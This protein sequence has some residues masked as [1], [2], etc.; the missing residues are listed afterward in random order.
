MKKM[1][2]T[3]LFTL[4]I[5][6]MAI[7]GYAQVAI[8]T[9]GD[10]PDS[11]AILDL[12]STSKGFLV[13]RVTTVQRNAIV[14]SQGG[15]LVY[16]SDTES[17]WYYNNTLS[18]WQEIGTI[19][20]I[21]INN[22][23][24]GI[25]NGTYMFIGTDAGSVNEGT[26]NTGIGHEALKNNTTAHAN[27]AL[28]YQ[29]LTAN[30]EGYA[31]TA[32][33]C[34]ALTKNTGGDYNTAIG[35]AALEKNT[36][37]N[38]NTALGYALGNNTSG[39][40]NTNIGYQSG[41][42]NTE[43]DYNVGVGN[44]TLLYNTTGNKNTAIGHGAGSS[45]DDISGC[46]L[47]GYWAGAYNTAD[48]KLFIDNSST[49]SPLIGG[50]FSTD[51]VDINGTLKITGGTPGDGKV[52]TSDADGLASWETA[53]GATSINDLSD[54]INDGTYMFLGTDAGTN[55]SAGN[56]NT[57]IGYEAMHMN[58]T[59]HLNT[60]LGYQ[61]LYSN[62]I[63]DG[64]LALGYS[65]LYNNT[66]SGN[67]AIGSQTLYSSVTGASNANIGNSS[68]Y[69]NNTGC[70][71]VGLGHGT[72]FYNEDGSQ[73]TAVGYHAG[74]GQTGDDI[75][76]C[77]FLGYSA[78]ENNT[79]DNKLFIDNSNT[80]TPL[81]GGDFSTDQVDI[82]GTLKITGGTPGDG[83]VLT[84]D[85]DGLA[86]WQTPSSGG[87]TSIN[88]LSDATNDGTKFF[89][90]TNAGANNTGSYNLGIGYEAMKLNTT[91]THNTAL[92]FKTLDANTE[93]VGNSAFGHGSLTGNTTG[94]YNT[95]IGFETMK[96]NSTGGYNTALGSRSLDANTEGNRNSAFGY[97]SLT[98]NTT[99][100]DNTSIGYDALSQN[101]TG[102]E[103]VAVGK[104][105][106]YNSE[107]DGNIFIGTNA[108]YNETGD[109]KLYIDNSNTTTPLIG[110]DFST[111]QVDIN[112]TLKI[113][114]GSPGADK[115]LTSDASGNATW[116]DVMQPI[117]FGTVYN[118]GQLY[119]NSGNVSVT[120]TGKGEYS[121]TISGEN[122]VYYNYICNATLVTT[123]LTCGFISSDDD[124]N[125][126][127][128]HTRDSS[129]NPEDF[130]FSFVVYKP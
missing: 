76:G 124:S 7:S 101:T 107:G 47:L 104:A 23:V 117:A 36:T 93:G 70:Y 69:H 127:I 100:D 46:V 82:N 51:Q 45:G 57:G 32:I 11:S 123:G 8:N 121:I 14:T 56:Y 16:D 44:F 35:R 6:L 96:L 78:G 106:G 29:T 27:T 84:S 95:S 94:L 42:G 60:A 61:A 99:G 120:R 115:V 15:L 75:S 9:T 10:E 13:P 24:D 40:N 77:V 58:Q 116:Q 114:G 119:A 21:G 86:S 54:A 79:A 63:G 103:N 71:N 12:Q 50:D 67:I 62:V 30:T 18:A 122:Y 22:L 26:Y 125:K 129:G 25:N 110:G 128:I 92:G 1:K 98:E 38:Y 33:G 74:Y 109:N 126:L 55:N 4:L 80:S 88:D 53:T 52:L 111:N 112:G 81:I 85:A 34:L 105:A 83:K 19:G 48:N 89:M 64:N 108:G 20:E 65:T 41:D 49:S 66:G 17:F 43:G 91:G 68:G 113:T 118:F 102:I 28:G 97:G 37:G 59:G 2:K 130:A 73:N 3:V 39:T 72:L 5:A 90:G 31:N 87:A